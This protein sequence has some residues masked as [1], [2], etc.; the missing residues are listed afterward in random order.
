MRFCLSADPASLSR[1]RRN[2]HSAW[3]APRGLDRYYELTVA[4]RGTADPQTGYFMNIKRIDQAV[5]T[6]AL[7][8]LQRRIQ[9]ESAA[10]TAPLGDVLRELLTA[11]DPE[12]DR[13]VAW[14]EL[15]LTPRIRLALRAHDM[16]HTLIRQQ[17]E[18]SAAHRL[19]AAGLSD[20]ENRA[21]FGKCNNPAGH[22][23]NY[24]LEVAIRSPIDPQGRP[25]DIDALDAAVD[26]LAIERL[27]HKHLNQDVAEFAKLNP[28]V[29]HIARVIWGW[30]HGRMPGGAHLEEVRVWETGKTSCAYRGAEHGDT[31]ATPP[32]TNRAQASSAPA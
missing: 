10:A 29:E 24:K 16:D 2:N 13:S 3:P 17:Y 7:P 20:D 26:D 14:I 15:A 21:V 31:N 30:L 4:C 22:G 1:P 19:H 27:D 25:L 18:F 28:S 5:R 11:L 23:H 9:S 12:L 8:A 32:A 6:A